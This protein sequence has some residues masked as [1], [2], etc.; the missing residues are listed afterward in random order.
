MEID[1]YPADG[2]DAEGLRE[3]W[4]A[5]WN[6]SDARGLAVE[7]RKRTEMASARGAVLSFP[8]GV[9]P[10][11]HQIDSALREAITLIVLYGTRDECLRAF[12]TREA[13]T[14]RNLSAEH[15]ILNNALSHGEFG[16]P[17]FAR[18]QVPAF[19]SGKFRAVGDIAKQVWHRAV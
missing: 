5:F 12:Q 8:S 3:E 4:D 7:I 14:G 11:D 16:A 15:W 17:R 6:D 1:R 19:S 2:I 13:A 10:A 18:F 9:V